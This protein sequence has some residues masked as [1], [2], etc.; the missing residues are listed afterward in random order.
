MHS[1]V[2]RVAGGIGDSGAHPT[3][4]LAMARRANASRSSLLRAGSS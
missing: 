2:E 1:L 3:R 4:W